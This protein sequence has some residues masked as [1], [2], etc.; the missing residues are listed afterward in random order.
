MY[1][2]IILNIIK[3]VNFNFLH[4]IYL[5]FSRTIYELNRSQSHT[6]HE[7]MLEKDPYGVTI[8]VQL[9]SIN[10]VDIRNEE[11]DLTVALMMVDKLEIYCQL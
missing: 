8:Q 6:M 7:D 4:L 11:I 1:C 9:I 5:L 2:M 3:H 10:D